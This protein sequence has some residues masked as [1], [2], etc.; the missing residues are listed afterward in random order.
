MVVGDLH[1]DH[2]LA[3]GRDP[4]AALDP[5]LLASLQALIVAGD[6]SDKPKVPWP[7]VL[8]HLARYVEPSRIHVFPGNHDYYG[9]GLRSRRCLSSGRHD[10]SAARSGQTSP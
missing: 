6:L 1:L 9:W 5:D 2:W 4:F 7:T 10:I 8:A 3:G